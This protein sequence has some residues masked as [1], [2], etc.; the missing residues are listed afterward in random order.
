M[1][2]FSNPCFPPLL[3]SAHRLPLHPHWAFSPQLPSKEKRPTG[4]SSRPTE[5]LLGPAA[6]QATTGTDWRGQQGK[7]P[8]QQ[9]ASCQQDSWV[10]E[11]HISGE[12]S[13]G[14][15]RQG[16]RLGRFS[17]DTVMSHWG[18]GSYHPCYATPADQPP[19]PGIHLARLSPVS[20][21]WLG[22]LCSELPQA[23]FMA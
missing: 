9:R 15:P 17:G 14:E 23:V 21:W 10:L 19:C 3:C 16:D 13:A 20:L 12:P 2:I 6:R 11:G 22:D 8:E 5:G 4:T 1:P 18:Q 7:Q